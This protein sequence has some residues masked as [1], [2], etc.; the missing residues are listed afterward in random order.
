MEWRLPVCAAD[1]IPEELSESGGKG[2][3]RH[4]SGEKG[5]ETGEWEMAELVKNAWIGW[6]DYITDGKLAAVL[7]AALIFLWLGKKRVEKK[8]FLLYTTI[9]TVCCIVPVTAAVLMAY[10]TKFYDY[11]WIWSMVPTTAVI[12]WAGVLFLEEAW[13]EFRPAAWRR[14]LPAAVLLLALVLFC[15][16]LGTPPRDWEQ[17]GQDKRQASRI[18]ELIKQQYPGEKLC[19]WAPR[20]IME[21]VREED[22]S[23]MIPYGRDMWN[24]SLRAYAYDTYDEKR[25]AMYQWMEST[26]GSQQTGTYGTDGKEDR[27]LTAETCSAYAREA[28]VT[29]VLVPDTAAPGTVRELEKALDAEAHKLE[30]YWIFY[31]WTD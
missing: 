29:C 22:G 5:F 28:G 16:G 15:G 24:A 9:M 2:A 7:M 23:V 13:P 1:Y 3:Q 14:G 4:Q 30:D 21:Y 27:E 8:S 10:Q 20:E 17:E 19:L 12:A 31:G 11:E 26:G 18:L 25:T 6:K